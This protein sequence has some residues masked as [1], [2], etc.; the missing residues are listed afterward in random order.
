MCKENQDWLPESE[1][2]EGP[3]VLP[4]EGEEPVEE[5]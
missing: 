1:P 3:D 5:N 2:P 4:E